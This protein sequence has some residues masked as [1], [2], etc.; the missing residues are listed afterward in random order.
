M[1]PPGVYQMCHAHD[2][3]P[4]RFRKCL[5]T[6]PMRELIL[7]HHPCICPHD[8]PPRPFQKRLTGPPMMHAPGH[9]PSEIKLLH[10]LLVPNKR[11]IRA[12]SAHTP[13]A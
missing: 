5:S 12:Y 9:T 7:G 6:F 4:D 11:R 8:D 2:H 1:C 3:P 13:K 10:V